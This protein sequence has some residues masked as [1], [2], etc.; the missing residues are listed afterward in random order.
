MLKNWLNQEKKNINITKGNISNPPL[1]KHIFF[2]NRFH[3]WV[4]LSKVRNFYAPYVR[5]KKKNPNDAKWLY[6]KMKK[7]KLVLYVSD[8]TTYPEKRDEKEG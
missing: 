7:K 2:W 4:Q 5:F 3:R 8:W 1:Q 6:K